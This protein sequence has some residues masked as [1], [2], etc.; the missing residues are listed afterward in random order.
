[1]SALE[2]MRKVGRQSHTRQHRL[3]TVI[4]RFDLEWDF[5]PFDTDSLQRHAPAVFS[6]LRIS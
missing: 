5:H 2:V 1:M 6:A 4:L 3:V